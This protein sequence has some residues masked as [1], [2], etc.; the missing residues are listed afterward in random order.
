MPQ[1]ADVAVDS[2]S[3]ADLKPF[4]ATGAQI[5]LRDL[6]E[7][8]DD[9]TVARAVL[10]EVSADTLGPARRTFALAFYSPGAGGRGWYAT[11]GHT[12]GGWNVV[13]AGLFFEP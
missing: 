4:A 2:L 9:K 10:Y 12:A 3:I 13:A 1:P 11:V 7:P 5:R 8:F 6:G